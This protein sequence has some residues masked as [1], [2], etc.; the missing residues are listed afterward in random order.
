MVYRIVFTVRSTGQGRIPKCEDCQL[1]TG[2]YSLIQDM[3]GIG[4]LICEKCAEN[5]PCRWDF[6]LEYNHFPH[7]VF[8]LID[9]QYAKW[10]YDSGWQIPNFPI[11]EK[12]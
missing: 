4:L 10:R 11:L 3:G 5:Y 8:T 12:I 7:M 9:Y 2:L 6:Y 1:Y